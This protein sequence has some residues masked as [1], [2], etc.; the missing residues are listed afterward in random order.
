MQLPAHLDRFRVEGAGVCPHCQRPV[1]HVLAKVSDN[2]DLLFAVLHE[3]DEV[4]STPCMA[5]ASAAR[6]AQEIAKL[7]V[8]P[9]PGI[10]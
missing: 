1:T 4:G 5:V 8:S 10:H 7:A 9:A 2:G 3:G 6:V